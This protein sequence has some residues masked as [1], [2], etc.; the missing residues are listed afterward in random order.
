MRKRVLA[1][2]QRLVLPAGQYASGKRLVEIGSARGHLLAALQQ[3][4][5]DVQG[6]EPSTTA[7]AQSR[8]T[9]RV[10]V[11]EGTAEQ[12][13]CAGYPRN[14]DIALAS[15]VIEH[16]DAPDVFVDACASLLKPNGILVM[17]M[18]NIDSFNAQAVGPAWEM[19]QK[20][21][22]YLFAPSS[23]ALLLE[24]RH[25]QVLRIFSSDNS[26]LTIRQSR[27]RKKMHQ[28]LL[29]LDRTGLYP[30][31]RSWYRR[32]K[33]P[34]SDTHH[35]FQA[36]TREEI[37]R[38]ESWENSRDAKAPLTAQQRGDHIVVIARKVDPLCPLGV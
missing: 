5:Y 35:G 21:H 7:A 37:A 15:T 1:Q 19:Y 10:P 28:R 25:F 38:L 18:P 27:E 6:V 31:V 36:I 4:G 16:V 8:A 14:F 34:L 26:P 23:I 29:L 12:Y 11:F 33:Y 9:Y 32:R 13:L 17:D 22:I 20:Y 3:M 2:I 24:K 30:L